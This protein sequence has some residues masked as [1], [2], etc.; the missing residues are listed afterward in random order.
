MRTRHLG[1]IHDM[2]YA[3]AETL[4]DEYRSVTGAV[5][6]E[7]RDEAE[8]S[9][10]AALIHAYGMHAHTERFSAAIVEPVAATTASA[11]PVKPVCRDCGGD[12]LVRDASA[13][14]DLDAQDWT[15]SGVYDSTYCD[16]CESESDDLCRWVAI[17]PA[18]LPQSELVIGAWVR[19]LERPRVGR[20]R[21]RGRE[22][23]IVKAHFAG[24]Y[25]KLNKSLREKIQKTELVETQYLEVLAVPVAK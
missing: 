6:H 17:D 9:R 5:D 13:R 7:F 8:R 1:N 10:Y 20:D 12:S 21:Y 18:E 19:I 15:M 25:V 24:F 4:A 23:I 22:G 14:W 2:I 16:D 3:T 11:S